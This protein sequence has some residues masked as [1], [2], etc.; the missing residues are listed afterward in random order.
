VVPPPPPPLPLL[1]LLLLLLLRVSSQQQKQ[2]PRRPSGAGCHVHWHLSAARS[3]H[4]QVNRTQLTC[5]HSTQ[6]TTR[7]LVTHSRASAQRH[8]LIVQVHYTVTQKK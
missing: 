4:E 5:R 6:F 7:L 8:D 2:T 3:T 1:L